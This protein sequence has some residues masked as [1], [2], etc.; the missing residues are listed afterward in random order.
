MT[1]FLDLLSSEALRSLL[2]FE[3]EKKTT[4]LK[5]VH[6]WLK[7]PDILVVQ[8]LWHPRK[9]DKHRHL[10]QQI[11]VELSLKHESSRG[12][13]GEVP[14]TEILPSF[15]SLKQDTNV[16]ITLR[17]NSLLLSSCILGSLSNQGILSRLNLYWLHC[18]LTVL[19]WK[20]VVSHCTEP[21]E[22]VFKSE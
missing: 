1:A 10:R 7:L 2:E 18:D 11:K 20:A 12:A 14:Q 9:S 5:P 8:A 3:L 19:W 16:L 6:I 4:T 13:L 15:F 21:F 17:N 22:R